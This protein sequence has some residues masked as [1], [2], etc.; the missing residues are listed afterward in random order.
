MGGRKVKVGTAVFLAALLM[1]VIAPDMASA[2]PKSA[3]PVSQETSVSELSSQQR[4]RRPRVVVTRQVRALPPDAVRQCRAWYVQEA[5]PS[6]VVIVPR[7]Q[8]WWERG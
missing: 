1:G 2:G 5:R 4:V 3:G 7:M 8:C 6:G